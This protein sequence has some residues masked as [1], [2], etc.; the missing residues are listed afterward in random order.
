MA[1][2]KLDNELRRKAEKLVS[3]GKAGAHDI[4]SADK[5]VLIHELEVHQIEL[6]LQNEELQRA[7]RDLQI[8][9]NHYSDLF[10]FAPVGY[11]ILDHHFLIENVNLSGSR[12]LDM[13][14]RRLPGKRFMSFVAQADQD[15]LYRC[16]IS[17][18]NAGAKGCEVKMQR[19]D[20]AQ[21]DTDLKISEESTENGIVKYRVAVV[22]I[23]DR[24]R[25]EHELAASRDDLEVRVRE[26]SEQLRRMTGQLTVAEQRERQ[27]LSQILHDGLQQILVGAKFR[28]AFIERDADPHGAKNEVSELIDDAIETSR[29]LTAE[30]SPPVLLQDNFVSALEWL[31]RWMRHKQGLH[32]DLTAHRKIRPLTTEARL[33]LFQAVRELLFNVVKHAGVKTAGVEVDQVDEEIL[34]TVEDYGAGFDI[35]QL[36]AEGYESC[37]IGLAG[38]QER[39]SYLGGRR[40]STALLAKEADSG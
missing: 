34:L 22:D 36:H 24:K 38:I 6:E 40:R 29:S 19:R 20:G 9:R 30:L 5:D 4:S 33:L 35:G 2:K 27:R 26:R 39:I 16:L 31:A 13:E 17:T 8:S 11:F 14:R 3:E 23:T 12:I 21:F 32:V 10:E 1:E 15:A 18:G 28:L 25:L 7:Q 37:G